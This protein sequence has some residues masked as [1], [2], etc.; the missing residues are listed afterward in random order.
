MA[1]DGLRAGPDLRRRPGPDRDRGRRAGRADPTRPSPAM[2][3]GI[4]VGDVIIKMDRKKIKSIDDVRRVLNF[5]EPG[6]KVTVEII[7]DK[8]KQTVEIEL[9]AYPDMPYEIPKELLDP[10]YWGD[11]FRDLKDRF[12]EYWR[13]FRKHDRKRDITT[14]PDYV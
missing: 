10:D 1:T 11:E 8:D 3:A 4:K 9:S 6:D 14:T 12:E 13:N 7:R 2:R 5:F